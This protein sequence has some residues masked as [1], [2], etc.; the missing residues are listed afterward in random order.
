MAFYRY[1]YINPEQ[2]EFSISNLQA[3]ILRETLST[4]TIEEMIKY[5]IVYSTTFIINDGKVVDFI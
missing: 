3:S 5:Y 2:G 4:L 1:N